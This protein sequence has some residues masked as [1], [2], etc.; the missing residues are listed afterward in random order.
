[1]DQASICS[2]WS[3]YPSQQEPCVWMGHSMES[4]SSLLINYQLAINSLFTSKI[5]GKDGVLK[6]LS[7]IPSLVA[8]N[9]QMTAILSIMVPAIIGVDHLWPSMEYCQQIVSLHHG[10]KFSSNH[11]MEDHTSVIQM[12]LIKVKSWTSK[13]Q[14]MSF[15]PSTT[16]I[17]T[18]CFSINKKSSLLEK[19]M[20][21][22]V[23]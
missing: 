4:I 16:S 11:V 20:V 22:L 2:I 3:L 9:T 19:E 18:I 12:Q 7:T 17:K 23:P 6:I 8:K 5:S 13:D 14:K 1:M 10:Q 15:K 21:Q